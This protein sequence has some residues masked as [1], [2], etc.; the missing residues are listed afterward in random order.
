MDG[1]AFDGGDTQGQGTDLTIGSGSYIDDFE[2]QLIGAHPGDNVTVKVTFPDNYGNDDLNGKDA[3]F[4][5]TVNGIY[6]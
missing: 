3:T 2:D 4:D 6:Q 5:V 1:K